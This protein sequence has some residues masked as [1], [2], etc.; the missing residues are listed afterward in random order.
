M[1]N[2]LDTSK[3]EAA[4]AATKEEQQKKDDNSSSKS[5]NNSEQISP[6][7]E[8]ARR[9]KGI[10]RLSPV[11]S[12]VT[13]KPKKLEGATTRVYPLKDRSQKWA[14]NG[15][16]I[17]QILEEYPV[18]GEQ[19]TKIKEAG[20]DGKKIRVWDDERIK[21]FVMTVPARGKTFNMANEVDRF[22]AAILGDSTYTIIGNSVNPSNGDEEFFFEDSLGDAREQNI[23]ER[24]I[25]KAK[26]V[27]YSLDTETIR[28]L[29]VS[30]G[31]S[32][33]TTS[34]EEAE[35]ILSNE[36]ARGK[37]GKGAQ[38]F[39]TMHG[40]MAFTNILIDVH[41]LIQKSIIK[42]D[43][44]S[45]TIVWNNL[46]LGLNEEEAA[47]F[48]AKSESQQYYIQLKKIIG[49]LLGKVNKE[50]VDDEFVEVD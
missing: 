44:V 43:P 21:K 27:L 25:F 41:I 22:F 32:Y 29:A 40:N 17:K 38:K 33:D 48:L 3:I 45:N 42:R 20:Q 26:E 7:L 50:V 18:V 28:R 4:T 6:A 14:F 31:N 49:G 2:P 36:I 35:A 30:Y 15:L 24:L 37:R 5:G 46:T 23:S 10:V 12:T 13:G 8:I 1:N 34:V 39:L 19:L 11:L 16:T 47:R 9:R